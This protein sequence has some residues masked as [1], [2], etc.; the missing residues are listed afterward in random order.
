MSADEVK[1]RKPVHPGDTL[2]IEG[3]LLRAKATIA[4]ASCRCLVN[5]EVTSEATLMFAY[6]AQ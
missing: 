3:E 2:I 1:F 5:G 4:K 6:V